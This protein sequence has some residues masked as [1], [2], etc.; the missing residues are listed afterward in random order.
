M[1]PCLRMTAE[2]YTRKICNPDW[3]PF[4]PPRMIKVKTKDD[5]IVLLFLMGLYALTQL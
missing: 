5:A 4:E 3:P 1:L 2:E